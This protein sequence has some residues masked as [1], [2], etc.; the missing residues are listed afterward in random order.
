VYCH[1][2]YGPRTPAGHRVTAETTDDEGKDGGADRDQQGIAHPGR[3]LGATEN[4]GE[5]VQG[6]FGG[7]V[8]LRRLILGEGDRREQQGENGEHAEPRLHASRT[9]HVDH[10]RRAW[11]T[12]AD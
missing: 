8:F 6:R 12:P 2:P 1:R 10:L 11:G 5:V 3:E 9:G 7:D 4:E